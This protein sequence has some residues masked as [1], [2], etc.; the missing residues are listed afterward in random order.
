MGNRYIG[1]GSAIVDNIVPFGASEPVTKRLGGGGVYA[2]TGIRLWEDDC[3][4]ALHTGK[5][6]EDL[7]GEWL[8]ANDIDWSGVIQDREHTRT[9]NLYYNEEGHYDNVDLY[10]EEYP[11]RWEN[12]SAVLLD[13]IVT[14]HTR[15][16]YTITVG[17]PGIL[18]DTYKII[19][20]RGARFGGEFSINYRFGESDNL[21]FFREN[22]EY[23]DF[24]S[25]NTYECRHL[26][27]GCR[28]AED[29]SEIMRSLGKPCFLREG[30]HGARF[31][32]DGKEYKSPL[33]SEF[34]DVDETGCGNTSTSAAF[35]AWCERKEPLEVSY[36]GAVTASANAGCEGLMRTLDQ[37][38]RD[39]CR[40]LV[41]QYLS[42]ERGDWR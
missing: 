6:F 20:E 29:A 31:I 2:F 17:D 5:D 38:L 11:K 40:H 42:G 7:Y 9:V 32:L 26:F 1:I 10:P 15:G 24:I 34:G 3:M 14:G 4:L 16:V 13:P 39:R 27:R 18:A 28:D 37:E 8:R 19:H 36:I 33:I 35:W 23:M 12:I 22:S 41:E 25:L 21:E 30:R